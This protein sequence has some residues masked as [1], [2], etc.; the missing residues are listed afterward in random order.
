MELG[1]TDLIIFSIRG[2]G[3]GLAADLKR[4]GL[5]VGLVDLTS[6]MGVWPAEDQEGPFGFFKTDRFSGNFLERMQEDD[7]HQPVKNGFTFWLKDGP[8]EMRGPVTSYRLKQLNLNDNEMN[9]LGLEEITNHEIDLS[10][11]LKNKWPVVFS[12]VFTKTFDLKAMEAQEAESHIPLLADFYIRRATRQGLERSLQWL[13]SLG[14]TVTTK[15]QALDLAQSSK[16]LEGFEFQGEWA[17][18][19]KSDFFVWCLSSEETHFL[20]AVLHKKIFGQT[21]PLEALWSWIRFRG[22]LRVTPQVE[23]WPDHF[24]LIEDLESPWTHENLIVVQRTGVADQFDFWIRIPNLQR[25]NKE[26]LNERWA[27]ISA[28]LQNRLPEI[29]PQIA[30]YPQ[31]YYYTYQELGPSPF[32]VFEKS[33]W[34]KFRHLKTADNLWF[35]SPQRWE[36]FDWNH[37]FNQQTHLAELLWNNWKQEQIRKEKRRDREV[38]TS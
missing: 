36:S 15:T 4:R 13:T 26:Y 12:H 7:H 31:E 11:G 6:M 24:V 14:V 35:Y 3:H 16:H 19:Q 34:Q 21:Q 28:Q 33:Q 25:F 22:K 18:F 8:L 20:S 30:S 29:L 17:G 5:N 10:Q 27:H 38:H 37:L 32:S 9:I 2:R 23:Q 1:N